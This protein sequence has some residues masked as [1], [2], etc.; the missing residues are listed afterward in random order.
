MVGQARGEQ[1]AQDRQH[2]S[3]GTEK[4]GLQPVSGGVLDT[5]RTNTMRIRWRPSRRLP[6]TNRDRSAQHNVWGR[7]VLLVGMV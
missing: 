7:D 4:A 5:N 6:L 2:K 1:A 3:A